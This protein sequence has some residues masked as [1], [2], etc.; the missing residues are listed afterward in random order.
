ML[1]GS[2]PRRMVLKVGSRTL[3]G[4]AREVVRERVAMIVDAVARYRSVPT[5]IVSSGAVAAGYAILG[6]PRPPT[7]PRERKAAAAVGQAKLTRMYTELFQERGMEAAQILLTNECIRDRRRYLDARSTLGDLFRSGVVP[8]VN[9]NDAVTS[10]E[11]EVG[12]NDNLA[13]YTAALV[14]ADLLVLLTDVSGVYNGNPRGNADARLV[15]RA[16]SVEELR[17]Y[18]FRKTSAESRGGMETKLQAAEKAAAFG[19]PT[20]IAGGDDPGVLTRVYT[21]QPVGTFVPGS[22]RPLPALRHWMASQMGITRGLVVDDGAAEAL[23]RGGASLLPR[24]VVGVKGRFEAGDVISVMDPRGKERARGVAAYGSDEVGRIKGH[25]SD[26]IEDLLGYRAGP[27]I[28][29]AEKLVI[30]DAKGDG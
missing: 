28:I 23:C 26:R 21:G 12:D 22:T 1:P 14:E 5:V 9:E 30:M 7:S 4:G 24:G 20:I 19:I 15:E 2:A 16:S 18:C 29:R 10:H 11:S 17:G 6:M 25:H 3:T 13:A 27:E 8:V